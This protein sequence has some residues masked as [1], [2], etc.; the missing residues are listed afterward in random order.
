MRK[1]MLFVALTTAVMAMGM[2]WA[3]VQVSEAKLG[4][5][6]QDRALTGEGTSF[7]AGSQV[8]VWM[9][10]TGAQA[11]DAVTVTWKRGGQAVLTTKLDVGGSPWRTW[12][13][14]TVTAG[15]WDASISDPSG[16]VLKDLP[17]TVK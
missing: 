4:T 14:K 17:F 7:P 12:A 15:S 3:G 11:G 10:L 9:S 8:Y 2:R 6:V 1:I 5:G 13:Q 16:T